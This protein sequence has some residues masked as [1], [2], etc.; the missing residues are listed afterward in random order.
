MD[1]SQIID[2][3]VTAVMGLVAVHASDVKRRITA[4]EA[5][6]AAV[7]QRITELVLRLVKPG[8]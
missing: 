4:T 7:N 2:L 8:D 6:I 3:L 1:T 5:H